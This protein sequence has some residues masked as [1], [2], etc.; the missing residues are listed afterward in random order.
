MIALLQIVVGLAIACLSASKFSS[1]TSRLREPYPH[2]H[3]S[4][5]RGIEMDQR[6][7]GPGL[8]SV[9]VVSDEMAPC[10]GLGTMFGYMIRITILNKVTYGDTLLV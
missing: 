1:F 8:E 10:S 3:E 4:R 5:P 7:K 6:A 2:S 9:R